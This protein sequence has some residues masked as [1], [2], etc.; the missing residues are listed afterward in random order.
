MRPTDNAE[1][2]VEAQADP[3]S[4][5][6]VL[7]PT[8]IGLK[9]GVDALFGAEEDGP[10]CRGPFVLDGDAPRGVGG[11]GQV[12][13]AHD[14]RLGRKVALKEMRADVRDK[15]RARRLFLME[16]RVTSQL[17]HPGIVPIYEMH[18]SGD[19]GPF[20]TMRYVEGRPLSALI[21]E[22]GRLRREGR[23]HALE[24]R[25]LL[26]ALVS[27][28]RT[29]A[30]AHSR[31]V[32]HRDLKPA[33]IQVG[34]YGEVVVLDW[35][36]ALVDGKGEDGVWVADP[37]R[38]VA[39][40]GTPGYM[41]PEQVRGSTLPVDA[42]SDVFALGAILY[43]ILE[44]HAPYRA[45]DSVALSAWAAKGEILPTRSAPAALAAVCRKALAA[46]PGGRYGTAAEVA[47]ELSRWLSGE[48]VR[49]Y[50]EPL[51]RRACRW[52]GRHRT[53]AAGLAAGLL[54]ALAAAG[55]AARDAQARERREEEAA[56]RQ[57]E[58]RL[59]GVRERGRAAEALLGEA[60][61]LAL[62]GE[63][64][65]ALARVVR[66]E[67]LLEQDGGDLTGRVGDLR[68][69]L[70][71]KLHGRRM[72][73]R[74]EAARLQGAQGEN[75]GC[76]T[77]DVARA[78]H[79]AFIEYLGVED[80]LK[81]A[82]EEAARRLGDA[83]IRL[84]LIA[85]LD[86]WAVR[87]VAARGW[88]GAVVGLLD[89]DPVRARVRR[90]VLA[91]DGA[92]L[93]GI[94]REGGI[95]HLPAPT[96]LGL[97]AQLRKAGH[98][99]DAERV[100]RL[101]WR[102]EPANF[103]AN[104]FLAHFLFGREGAG[105]G[106][107]IR[108]ATAAVA[109]RE[110]S[111]MA[112]LMLGVML[113]QA[114]RVTEAEP[115][116]R[117]AVRLD[118]RSA[119][120]HAHLGILLAERG[121]RPEAE[122][123]FRAALKI[124]GTFSL[125]HYHL[126]R[127]LEADGPARA[128]GH[129]AAAV[130]HDPGNEDAR[131]RWAAALDALGERSKAE[132][133]YRELIARSPR[134]CGGHCMLGIL[135]WC[136]GDRAE[137][138]RLVRR[139]AELDAEN[140]MA[141]R[142][143][144]MMLMDTGR[145]AEA[146]RCLKMSARLDPLNGRTHHQLGVLLRRQGRTREASA[147]LWAAVKADPRNAAAQNALGEMLEDEG[148]RGEALRRYRAALAANGQYAAAHVNAGRMLVKRCRWEEAERHFWAAVKIDGRSVWAWGHLGEA[149]AACGRLA[150]AIACH[151]RRAALLGPTHANQGVIRRRIE[152]LR[153]DMGM[154]AALDAVVAGGPGPD[155]D[156]GRVE[157]AE[158]A[159]RPYLGHYRLAVRLY[160]EAFAGTPGLAEGH[161]YNAA[162]AAAKAGCGGGDGETRRALR[163]GA[164]LW[165]T[166]WVEARKTEMESADPEAVRGARRA[167]IHALHDGDFDGVREGLAG[168]PEGERGRWVRLWAE[169]E[170][171]AAAGR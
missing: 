138:E 165:L 116:L 47:D 122:G 125:A 168:L 97:G 34:Q 107:A 67:T 63:A 133:Q 166:D 123:C 30:Y 152:K 64:A 120:A 61:E 32:V 105:R 68:R 149:L 40:G 80:A 136:K 3:A 167:L 126:G 156:R 113:R 14:G 159:Q 48:P 129:Y 2:S 98:H 31:G 55:W 170:G 92:A 143:L 13:L 118:A 91:S 114:G 49:A 99:E 71:R 134:H 33:N 84:E 169:V 137:G 82:P 130:R 37:V 74:L 115:A 76:D 119:F 21:E 81:M 109:V 57:A 52:V 50:P 18:P 141:H 157:M 150:E 102:R 86:D 77:R 132:G 89:G 148:G 96:L 139:A 10:P 100:L 46:R 56:R 5:E 124:D 8:V 88:I 87:E 66:A 19:G 72:R 69:E 44:G 12:W 161:R 106:D 15:E 83:D 146:E 162:C 111:S 62:R 27:V 108:Y 75:G 25:E 7:P 95:E 16:A 153:R 145:P 6:T 163:D 93:L 26:S 164:F 11:M 117:T 28:C 59:A 128:E 171:L 70:E 41:A 112:W 160:A 151:E 17:Q 131:F 121:E 142:V 58:A 78:Y 147:R 36:L 53:L 1:T 94:A 43:T 35:G 73:S 101:A 42:R 155:T 23:P 51:V 20:Y 158:L 9:G 144:G 24:L 38:T 127:L 140:A 104:A 22:V 110:D 154:R 39:F 65:Q 90:A 85:A 60:A 79:R 54:V 4:P 103:W 135:L 45:A 29:M